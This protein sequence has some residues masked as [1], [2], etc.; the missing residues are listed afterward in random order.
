MG[1]ISQ[2]TLVV[3]VVL[4]IREVPAMQNLLRDLTQALSSD[5]RLISDGQ[6]LKNKIVELALNFDSGLLKLLLKS[7]SITAHFF[8]KID[9]VIV[10]DSAKFLRFVNNKQFLPDS[11][12]ALKN[13]IGLTVGDD[14][15]MDS[16]KVMLSWPYKDCVLE[17]GQEDPADSRRE[18]FWNEILA[19][20]QIDRLLSPKVLVNWQ[21][22][23]REK[24]KKAIGSVSPKDNLIIKGNNLL[25]LHTLLKVYRGQVKLIFIDPPFNTENDSF[26]YNDTFSQ[27]TWLTFLKNRLEVAKELLSSDGSIFVHIDH[28]NN[29]PVKMLMDEVF[30][31]ENFRNEIILPGRAVKGLQQQFDT[32]RKLQIRHDVL[33][34]YTRNPQTTFKPYWVEKH[35]EGN[36]EGHWHHAWSTADRE[37]MQFELLG[38]K[39][40]KGQWVWSEKVCLKAIEN[41]KR[42]MDEGGGRTLAQYW[43][44]TGEALRFIRK[45]PDDGR[46]QYWRAPADTQLADTVW[47]GVP[48]YS[49]D[50]GFKTAKNERYLAEVIKL[51]SEEGDLV[52][53]FFGGSGTTAATAHKLNRHWITIEQLDY[54]E[55]TLLNRLKSVVNGDKVGISASVDWEG[56][57]DF[58]YCELSKANELFEDEIKSATT[59]KALFGILERMKTEA[60]LSYQADLKA[61]EDNKA[62][63]TKLPLSNQKKLLLAVLD[64]NF[65]YTPLSEIE[66]KTYSI[67]KAD[68]KANQDFFQLG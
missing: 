58:V 17:G 66:D 62:E 43:S 50:H 46:P 7:E 52:L 24:Q 68:K 44:D 1:V 59:T 21:R 11:F 22:F 49:A 31:R 48:I 18:V 38:T 5:E 42:F 20:D 67:S 9:D 45:S 47:T 63:V 13:K 16:R 54:V 33:F 19:P 25:A 61:F 57:G 27:S 30:D 56:G 6:L 4:S 35:K 23:G 29:H 51:A 37:T 32:L 41:Y 39:I 10:F 12:T 34:W 3:P 14:Y 28:D 26:K 2:F 65:L 53:D 15:L 40:S 8:K 36:P 55:T 60:F 64:K